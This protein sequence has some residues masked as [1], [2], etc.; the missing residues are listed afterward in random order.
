MFL[1]M[2]FPLHV[3]L[4]PLTKVLWSRGISHQILEHN[5]D[6]QLWLT[7]AA[8][9]PEALDLCQQMARGDLPSINTETNQSRV[10]IS[11]FG[12]LLAAPMTAGILAIT[13]L[14]ALLTGMGDQLEYIAALSFYPIAL[15]P[16]PYLLAGWQ[17]LFGEPWRLLTPAWLHFGWLHLVFNCLWWWDLGRRIEQRQS[18]KR[19]WWLFVIIALISNLAQAWQGAHLFGGLSGVIYGLLGYI[20]LWDRLR[21]PVF[22]LPQGILIFMLVWLLL[23]LSNVF[24]VMGMG[25]MANMAHLGGLLAGLALAFILSM[26]ESRRDSRR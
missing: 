21:N 15:Q 16:E 3:D 14:L 9:A 23:G 11:L 7:K 19:L 12:G 1:V 18:S 25:N 20:W 6:Q 10:R 5:E 4:L 17:H 2:S 8:Q 13:L 24:S 22:F 26:I